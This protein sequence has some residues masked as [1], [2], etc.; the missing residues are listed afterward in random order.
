MVKLDISHMRIVAGLCFC[1][2]FA[3]L[4]TYILIVYL[5]KAEDRHHDSAQFCSFSNL[6]LY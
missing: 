5:L 4:W 2:V 6:A 3:G 1:A